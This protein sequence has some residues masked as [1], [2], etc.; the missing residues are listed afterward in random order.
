MLFNSDMKNT[1]AEIIM[2]FGLSCHQYGDDTWLYHMLPSVPK[3]A[4][5]ALNQCPET[6]IINNN[7]QQVGMYYSKQDFPFKYQDLQ[8]A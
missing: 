6:V 4:V 1:L 2:R 3:E 5:N 7:F 8:P